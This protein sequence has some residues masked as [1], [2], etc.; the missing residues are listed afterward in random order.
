[1]IWLQPG[2]PEDRQKVGGTRERDGWHGRI[3]QDGLGFILYRYSV[4]TN[5]YG[6]LLI[7]SFYLYGLLYGWCLCVCKMCLMSTMW[8]GQSNH[9][10]LNMIL[11]MVCNIHHGIH[12]Y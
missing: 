2:L 5:A 8:F 12:S 3:W 6:E 9:E 10:V 11:V 4:G 1:M 7:L